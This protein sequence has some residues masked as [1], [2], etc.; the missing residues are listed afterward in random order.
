[1]VAG[2]L[3]QTG[4]GKARAG[5]FR[6]AQRTEVDVRSGGNRGRGQAHFEQN[7][8][9]VRHS[10]WRPGTPSGPARGAFSPGRVPPVDSEGGPLPGP[11]PPRGFRG[12]FK[13]RPP[14]TGARNRVAASEVAT[15]F[16]ARRAAGRALFAGRATTI[17]ETTDPG[18]GTT[19]VLLAFFAHLF[20]FVP[21]TQWS[22][23]NWAKLVRE[24]RARV[25]FGRRSGPR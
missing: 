22:R 9:P 16:P 3:G 6:A 19:I 17:A 5:G 24:R 18:L 20:V 14:A 7:L 8:A 23:E 2:K 12:G 13:A 11:G 15:R 4:P 21:E 25:V 1:M 10:F